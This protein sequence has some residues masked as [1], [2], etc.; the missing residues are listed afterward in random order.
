[1]SRPA[2]NAT[3]KNFETALTELEQVVAEME[4]GQLPLEQSL[5]A[6]QR[7]MELLRFC[8]ATLQDAQQQV[9]IMEA[10]S[11]RDFS[12]DNGNASAGE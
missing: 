2:K 3:P 5:A 4:A 6:Y 1:M 8:Q 9:K 10:G 11:I 12:I 7:G